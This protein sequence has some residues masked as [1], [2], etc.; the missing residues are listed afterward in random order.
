YSQVTDLIKSIR[1]PL[2]P[3]QGDGVLDEPLTSSEL[4]ATSSRISK[5]WDSKNPSKIS[6]LPSNCSP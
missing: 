1:R 5:P 4:T 2:P 6:F 3:E